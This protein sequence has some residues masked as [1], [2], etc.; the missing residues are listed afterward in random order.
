MLLLPHTPAAGHTCHQQHVK[1]TALA[2]DLS[3]VSIESYTNME[4][5]ASAL[6]LLGVAAGCAQE[7][8]HGST[9]PG[10]MQ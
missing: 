3:K 8:I 5:R 2:A 7:T 6:G 1:L 4:V 9:P 10:H